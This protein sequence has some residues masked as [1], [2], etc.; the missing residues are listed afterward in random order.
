VRNKIEGFENSC[1]FFELASENKLF[2]SHEHKGVFQLK[3]NEEF[4]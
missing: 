3:I 2:V 1:R 4:T